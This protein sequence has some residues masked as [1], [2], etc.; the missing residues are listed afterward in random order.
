LDAFARL[1]SA[2]LKTYVLGSR[3][4]E[5]L[6]DAVGVTPVRVAGERFERHEIVLLLAEHVSYGL[7]A[8]RRADG[9][10]VGFHTADWTLVEGLIDKLQD[11]YHLQKG[12]T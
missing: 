3:H 5:R 8:M 2:R 9:R 11:A 10:L 1:G 6:R 7:L 4:P 12:A